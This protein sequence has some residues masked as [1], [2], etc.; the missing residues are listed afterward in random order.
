MFKIIKKS[1]PDP[2]GFFRILQRIQ[3]DPIVMKP[4]KVNEAK[5]FFKGH[6]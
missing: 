5:S 2:T 6:C 1:S 3:K 4:C